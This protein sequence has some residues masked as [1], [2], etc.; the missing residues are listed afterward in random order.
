MTMLPTDQ[1]QPL[2]PGGVIEPSPD[3]DIER[4]S[5]AAPSDFADA[6]ESAPAGLHYFESLA[7]RRQRWFVAYVE[8]ARTPEMR[9]RRIALAVERLRGEGAV[10]A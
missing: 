6:L 9:R 8:G 1:L 4:P 7:Y 10:A 5:V 3:L 2:R